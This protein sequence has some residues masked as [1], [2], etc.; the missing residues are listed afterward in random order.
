M[1][2]LISFSYFSVIFLDIWMFDTREHVHSCDINGGSF[3][4]V[5]RSMGTSGYIGELS[6]AQKIW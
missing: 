5:L 2:K 4:T 3:E 6:D 1:M